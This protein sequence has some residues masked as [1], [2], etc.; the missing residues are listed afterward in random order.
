MRPPDCG[1]VPDVKLFSYKKAQFMREQQHPGERYDGASATSAPIST[2]SDCTGIRRLLEKSGQSRVKSYPL[3][4]DLGDHVDRE[5]VLWLWRLLTCRKPLPP[6]P[7][8][9]NTRDPAQAAKQSPPLLL[10]KHGLGVVL[11]FK[12]MVG[13]SMPPV[14]VN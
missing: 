8:S 4:A 11:Y 2:D 14:Y 13:Q 9:G 3:D 5:D 7:L 12:F 10:A 6:P 1:P